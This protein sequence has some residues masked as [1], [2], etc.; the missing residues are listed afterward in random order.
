[1]CCITSTVPGEAAC[2]PAPCAGGQRLCHMD[3]QCGAN[4]RCCTSY[5]FGWGHG[6]CVSG[7]V[8]PP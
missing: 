8:C 7:S 6:V 4:Q 1:V 2:R 5:A 3:A